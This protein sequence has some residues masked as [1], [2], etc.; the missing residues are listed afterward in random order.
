M[1][2]VSN[3]PKLYLLQ[4]HSIEFELVLLS[5]FLWMLP[6]SGALNFY[7]NRLIFVKIWFGRQQLQQSLDPNTLFVLFN[8]RMY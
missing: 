6:C 5:H 1:W 7:V 8:F 3:I 2:V 4:S